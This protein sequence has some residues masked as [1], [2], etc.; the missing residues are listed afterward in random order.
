MKENH[1]QAHFPIRISIQDHIKHL[2]ASG[3][4]IRRGQV[5]KESSLKMEKAAQSQL[6]V[7]WPKV[8]EL[9]WRDSYHC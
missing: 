6:S 1:I 4:S 9:N 2:T 3:K 5:Q 8:D 7:S